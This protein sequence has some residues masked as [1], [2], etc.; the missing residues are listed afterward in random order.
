MGVNV[1][2]KNAVGVNCGVNVAGVNVMGRRCRR[3]VNVPKIQYNTIQTKFVNNNILVFLV[4]KKIKLKLLCK[5]S[6]SQHNCFALV[7]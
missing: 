7:S 3:G 5:P 2:G 1:V 6:W 4:I